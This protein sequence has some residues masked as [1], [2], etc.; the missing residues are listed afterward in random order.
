MLY[1]SFVLCLFSHYLLTHLAGQQSKQPSG[2]GPVFTQKP[3]IKQAEKNIIFDCK[4]TADP[5]PSITWL[6][7][8]KAL[9]DGGRYKLSHTV[10]KNT[11]S[12][13]LEI[14]DMGIQDG[15]EYKVVAKNSNGEATA[16]IN[17]NLEGRIALVWVLNLKCAFN[18]KI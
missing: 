7:G 8:N 12:I 5:Q 14:M 1:F 6:H 4:L 3:Q 2:S 13:S 11:H 16:T 9:A 17:L 18:D 15:G 10:D